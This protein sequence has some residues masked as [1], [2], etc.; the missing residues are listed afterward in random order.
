LELTEEGT[1]RRVYQPWSRSTPCAAQGSAQ[2]NALV[3]GI[4]PWLLSRAHVIHQCGPANV[5][6]IQQRA[7]LPAGL[8]GPY[9]VSG[10]TGPELPDVLALADVVISRSGAG[11]IAEITALGLAP[12]LLPLAR[13]AG[14]E[15]RRNA[16][17]LAGRGAAV[18]LLDQ[19]TPGALHAA[20]GPLLADPGY[21]GAVAGKARS[22]GRPEAAELLADAVLSAAGRTGAGTAGTTLR[23][24]EGPAATTTRVAWTRTDLWPRPSAMTPCCRC[25]P[26]RQRPATRRTLGT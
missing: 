24:G 19:V 21:R 2:L 11:A 26:S 14:G 13:S 18:A 1:A 7:V 5:E 17:H 16:A 23:A 6:A 22:L 9:L 3:A 25:S 12:V 8:L 15:Q 10:F 4:L 20:L